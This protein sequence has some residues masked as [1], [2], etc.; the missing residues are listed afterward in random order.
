MLILCPR[1]SC[2]A[3]TVAQW[4]QRVWVA[5]LQTHTS[6]Y[7][8]LTQDPNT[9][10]HTCEQTHTGARTHTS[11]QTDRQTDTHTHTVPVLQTL[12]GRTLAA[13]LQTWG[14][15]ELLHQRTAPC[16]VGTASSPAHTPD[17]PTRKTDIKQPQIWTASPCDAVGGYTTCLT[18]ANQNWAVWLELSSLT[19]IEQPD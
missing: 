11:T 9:H 3:H 2:M 7:T 18:G 19:R 14:T 16:S 6:I 5:R 17:T 12:G 10:M 1:P 8:I 13:A 4:Y 15:F